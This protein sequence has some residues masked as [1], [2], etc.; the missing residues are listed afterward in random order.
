MSDSQFRLIGADQLMDKLK[1][2]TPKL[3]EAA[4]KRA[5]RK[6][7]AIVRKAAQVAAKGLDDPESPERIWKNVYLQQSRRGSKA[8]GGVMMRVGITGGARTP[9]GKDPKADAQP[10]GDTRHWRFIELG[11]EHEPAHPFLRPALENNV[12]SVTSTLISELSTEL[13]R[14]VVAR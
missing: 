12:S 5:A 11:T 8:I 7:M 9:Y 6:A 4:G 10:G 3:Q 1:K 2:L 13:D 14:L